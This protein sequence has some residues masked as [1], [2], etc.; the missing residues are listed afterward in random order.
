VGLDAARGLG[1]SAVLDADV[2][3]RVSLLALRR[4]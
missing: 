1:L 4:D 3:A 2:D